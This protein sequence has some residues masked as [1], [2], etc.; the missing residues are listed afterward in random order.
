V[1]AHIRESGFEIEREF[2]QNVFGNRRPEEA[3]TPINYG[4]ILARRRRGR[5]GLD[6][7]AAVTGRPA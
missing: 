6:N 2:V 4:A 5:L 1:R 7:G 3:R